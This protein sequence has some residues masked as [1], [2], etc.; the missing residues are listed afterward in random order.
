MEEGKE[1]VEGVEGDERM[2]RVEGGERMERGE[3]EEIMEM[4]GGEE[5]IERAEG[6]ERIWGR[7][8]ELTWAASLG[9]ARVSEVVQWPLGLGLSRLCI[10]CMYVCMWRCPGFVGV[11]FTCRR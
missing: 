8:A 3:G 5:R 7:V 6:E 10:V 9:Q 11:D 4:K 2:E 1:R